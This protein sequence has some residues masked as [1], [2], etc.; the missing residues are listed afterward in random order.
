MLLGPLTIGTVAWASFL[1]LGVRG[2]RRLWVAFAGL[3]F[4][5]ALAGAVIME[6]EGEDATFSGFIWIAL[7]VGSF[8]HTLALRP[9]F[10]ERLELLDDPSLDA[11]EDREAR[12]DHARELA[13]TDPARARRL[14]IGRPDLANAF[15]AGLVDVNS[16][17]AAAIAE[18]GGVSLEAAEVVVAG[19]PYSSL[20]DMDL[21]VNLPREQLARLRDVAVFLPPG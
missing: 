13:R 2:R 15:H 4:A 17:P 21:V 8:V 16:A 3:Y 1:Y 7:A 9:A 20:E 11:A 6:I 18:A 10:E 14:G 19:R 5:A 12:R